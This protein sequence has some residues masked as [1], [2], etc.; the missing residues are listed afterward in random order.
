MK[1]PMLRYVA[2][3]P[4]PDGLYG[5]RIVR[6]SIPGSG[7]DVVFRD[8]AEAIRWGEQLDTLISDIVRDAREMAMAEWEA[9]DRG[10]K[11][12]P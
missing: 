5:V 6:P 9:R 7:L 2:F 3:L 1:H 10:Q 8:K 11:G 12:K 4:K